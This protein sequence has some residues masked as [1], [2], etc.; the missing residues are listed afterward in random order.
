MSCSVCKD[1]EMHIIEPGEHGRGIQIRAGDSFVIR[2]H[3]RDGA[4]E[5]PELQ[6]VR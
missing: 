6:N 2:R 1:V 5:K 4:Q 3:T